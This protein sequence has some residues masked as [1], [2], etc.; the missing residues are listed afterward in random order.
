M[1]PFISP[2]L[3]PIAFGFLLATIMTF[4]ISGISTVVALGVS[5][6]TF[7]ANWMK[8]WVSA[9]VVAFP[10]ILFVAPAVRKFVGK[11]TLQN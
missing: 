2:K 7:L 9:W 6:P 4:I 11:M 1:R 5:D 3:A 10:T 8:S